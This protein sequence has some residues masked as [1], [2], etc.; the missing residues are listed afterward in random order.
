M[1]KKLDENGKEYLHKVKKP[2]NLSQLIDSFLTFTH[3][4]GEMHGSE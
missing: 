4:P 3:Q 1:V 2:V